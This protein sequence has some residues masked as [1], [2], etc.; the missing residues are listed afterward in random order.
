VPHLRV[1]EHGD[2]ECIGLLQI[3]ELDV[4]VVVRDELAC[5]DERPDPVLPLGFHGDISPIAGE[6]GDDDAR[7]LVA[8]LVTSNRRTAPSRRRRS[9]RA[10]RACCPSARTWARSSR[11]TGGGYADNVNDG[12]LAGKSDVEHYASERDREQ[13]EIEQ[14]PEVEALEVMELLQSHGLTV[15]ESTPVVEALRKRP[16]A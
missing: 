13:L 4:D 8:G 14:K 3:A 1:V 5:E 12:Y 11:R 6:R 15:E 9:S 10:V 2:P 7:D 16:E